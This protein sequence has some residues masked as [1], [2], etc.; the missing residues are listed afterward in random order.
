MPLDQ[1]R[2][3]I[4]FLNRRQKITIGESATNIIEGEPLCHPHFREIIGMVRQRFPF[5]QVSITTN[6]HRLDEDTVEFL[7]M[8]EPVEISI[9]LNSATTKGRAVL[10]GD[11]PRVAEQTL[12]GVKLLNQYKIEFHG[13]IVAMPHL[14]GWNDI[15]E[16]VRYLADNGAM[17]VRIFLPAYSKK[18]DPKLHFDITLMQ[19]ELKAFVDNT[20]ENTP[21]PVL[22]EPSYVSDLIP[23]ISGVMR[24]TKA[25][26]AG[27]KKGDIVKHVNGRIPRSRVEAWGFMQMPGIIDVEVE[28]TGEF[29]KL[30][31][32]NGGGGRS[33]AIP[34]YDFDMHRMDAIKH[35]ILSTQGRVLALASEFAFNV[36]KAVF[37]IMEIPEQRTDVQMVKN[38]LFGGSIMAAGLLSVEDFFTAFQEYCSLHE[39]PDHILIPLEPFDWQGY[40]ITGRHFKE[41]ETI[42]GIEVKMM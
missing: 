42:T 2:E 36:L 5:T 16:T 6:G 3:T 20:S 12:E 32:D 28:R 1:V 23:V 8:S 35:F 18:S 4:R 22:L 27:L 26:E 25:R 15:E 14:V 30:R 10:M 7:K 33:G 17:T 41:L 24:G 21:C 9:S 34:G 11:S 39:R 13:S 29:S 31:W 40:D 38:H 19:K 37:Q